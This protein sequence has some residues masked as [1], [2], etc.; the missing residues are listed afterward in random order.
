MAIKRI[1]LKLAESY[2]LNQLRKLSTESL[3]I[4]VVGKSQ[5]KHLKF[6]I[7]ELTRKCSNKSNKTFIKRISSIS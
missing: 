4:W 2:E 1:T 5:E 3:I 7:E 6:S